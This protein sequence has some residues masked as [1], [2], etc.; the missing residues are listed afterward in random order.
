MTSRFQVTNLTKIDQIFGQMLAKLGQTLVK[1]F[2][3]QKSDQ[4]R[5]Q[6]CLISNF[7]VGQIPKLVQMGQIF[8]NLKLSIFRPQICHF[9]VFENFDQNLAKFGQNLAKNLV[10]FGQNGHVT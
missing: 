9:L 6:K 2:K 8:Q 1:I 7:D 5:V 4:Y 3:N 10:K